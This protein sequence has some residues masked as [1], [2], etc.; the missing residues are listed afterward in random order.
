V[1]CCHLAHRSNYLVLS[2]AQLPL[3]AFH[4]T[5]PGR[6]EPFVLYIDFY[7]EGTL[8]APLGFSPRRN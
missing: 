4:I 7:D 3:D 8:Y 5:Y 1:K 6:S 2:Q